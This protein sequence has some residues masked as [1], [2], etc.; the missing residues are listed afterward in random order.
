MTILDAEWLETW[1][2]RPDAFRP[3]LEPVGWRGSRFRML[4]GL[5]DACQ[6]VRDG[7]YGSLDEEGQALYRWA[8]H[9]LPILQA[10][11]ATD[12]IPATPE[13]R[14]GLISVVEDFV[15][16]EDNIGDYGGYDDEHYLDWR[17][18]DD[19]DPE[20]DEAERYQIRQSLAGY[21]ETLDALY[22]QHQQEAKEAAQA[23]R[24]AVA[25]A[26]KPWWQW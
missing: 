17:E 7:E 14:A 4:S 8:D 11:V 22:L 23:R 20:S 1:G 24:E 3:H 10:H 9:W 13:E 21:T 16:Y 18:T 2:N 15:T 5:I 19:R 12:W 26:R 6:F 25:K